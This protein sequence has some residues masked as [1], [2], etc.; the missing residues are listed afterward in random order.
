MRASSQSV[1]EVAMVDKEQIVRAFS[2]SKLLNML[3][4]KGKRRI[5]AGSKM[6]VFP[7]GFSVIKEGEPGDAMYVIVEG[8]ATVT[9]DDLGK[10][11][12]INQLNEF[13]VFGEMAVITNQPRSAT[14][15][16][17]GLTVLKIP[18]DLILTIL[19]DYPKVKEMVGRMG[20][21]RTEETLEKMLKED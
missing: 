19:N 12:T 20:V 3:D 1:R 7:D 8:T 18:R 13:S 17:L 21:Q 16:A 14:V 15:H 2:G 6:V 11:K 5:L 10:E 4:D 9:A